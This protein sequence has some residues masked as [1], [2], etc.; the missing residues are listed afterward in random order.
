MVLVRTESVRRRQGGGV[1]RPRRRHSSSA[2]SGSSSGGG[3][4]EWALAGGMSGLIADTLVHPLDTIST[5]QKL[6][7][8][9]QYG[10]FAHTARE[11]ARREGAFG[12]L[13]GVGATVMCALPATG[14]YLRIRGVEAR[15]LRNVW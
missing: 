9:S 4:F 14:L 6:L 13:F 12:D 11:I 15:R 2:S 10:S 7:P 1:K 8:P 5:R 3:V